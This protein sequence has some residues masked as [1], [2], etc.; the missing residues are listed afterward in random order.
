MSE[1]PVDQEVIDFILANKQDYRVSTTCSGPVVAPLEVKPPKDSDIR[2]KIGY[3]T[4]YVS[5]VQARYIRRITA[6]MLDQ[7]RWQTCAYF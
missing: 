4:L 7:T 2:I 6:D 5:K 1:L 3:Y